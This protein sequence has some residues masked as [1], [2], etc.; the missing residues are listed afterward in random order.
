MEYL[1]LAFMAAVVGCLLWIGLELHQI[2]KK[3]PRVYPLETIEP[4]QIC[5]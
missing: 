2:G 1:V 3:L 4:W 5:D